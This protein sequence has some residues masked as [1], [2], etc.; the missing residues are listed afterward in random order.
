MNSIKTASTLTPTSS[1]FFRAVLAGVIIGLSVE[2]LLNFLGVGLG[3]YSFNMTA[4]SLE[5]MGWG[6]L[7]WLAITGILAMFLGGWVM[8]K[9]CSGYSIINAIYHGLLAWGLATLITVGTTTTAA[10]SII[11]GPIGVVSSSLA[12]NPRTPDMVSMAIRYADQDK[13]TASSTDKGMTSTA[14]TATPSNESQVQEAAET[15]AKAIANA[16]ITLFF[17]FFL[18]AIASAAGAVLGRNKGNSTF[19]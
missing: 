16:A 9:F 2:V 12:S 4:I 7:G 3:L 13:N 10:G 11:G 18:S 6:A 1:L 14:G 17:A 8:G 15:T 19:S 5:Q